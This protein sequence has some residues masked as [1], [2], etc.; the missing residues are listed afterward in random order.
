MRQRKIKDVENK[1]LAYEDLIIRNPAEYR[2]RWR[3]AFAIDEALADEE[4]I[5]DAEPATGEVDVDL[6]NKK[7]YVEIGCGK[8]QF[9]T[10]SAMYEPESLFVAIEGFSS[11][12][13]KALQKIRKAEL[14]N[15]RCILDFVFVLGTWFDENELDGIFLNFSDPWPKKKNAKRRLTYRDRLEQYAIALKPDGF[16]WFKT[17][18]DGLFDFTLEELDAVIERCGF[19]IE[20]MTRDLHGTEW[21]AKSPMT[22]YEAKFSGTGKNINFL[23]LKKK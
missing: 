11:V 21:A 18:N 9:I 15:V 1:I 16:L 22:E 17:D 6:R 4:S 20:F 7:L 2:G 12:L 13:Y 19:E 8:G 3:E 23:A 14:G 5:G 10:A